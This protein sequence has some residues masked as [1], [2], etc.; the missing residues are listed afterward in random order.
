MPQ[1][2]TGMVCLVALAP[3][4]GRS[5]GIY[6]Y[7]TAW[8]RRPVYC[9]RPR[10]AAAS[11]CLATYL[12]AD[13]QRYTPIPPLNSGAKAFSALYCKAKPQFPTNWACLG[14]NPLDLPRTPY[15]TSKGK[16]STL[17]SSSDHHSSHQWTAL[18]LS[19]YNIT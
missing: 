3:T 4:C 7:C 9:N 16:H 6:S 19:Y 10:E 13:C 14:V 5:L 18:F 17:R 12:W 2:S 15:W 8:Y 1:R 11:R